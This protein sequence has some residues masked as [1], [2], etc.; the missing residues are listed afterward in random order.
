MAKKKN[1]NKKKK[2]GNIINTVPQVANSVVA[3]SIVPNIIIAP[4]ASGQQQGFQGF[5]V[6]KR[7]GTFWPN[8]IYDITPTYINTEIKVLPND[9][10]TNRFSKYYNSQNIFRYINNPTT[11]NNKIL[12]EYNFIDYNYDELKYTLYIGTTANFYC[13]SATSRLASTF[14]FTPSNLRIADTGDFL[15][16]FSVNYKTTFDTISSFSYVL[17][18]ERLF[19]YPIE[20]YY[21]GNNYILKTNTVLLSSVIYIYYGQ[22]S[23]NVAYNKIIDYLY[24]NPTSYPIPNTPPYS[25]ITTISAYRSVRDRRIGEI[26]L[27]N[28]ISNAFLEYDIDAPNKFFKIRPDSTYITYDTDYE[29]NNSIGQTL[30]ELDY[31]GLPDLKTSLILRQDLKTDNNIQ[32]FQLA[33]SSINTNLKLDDINNTI[34]TLTLNLTSGAITHNIFSPDVDEFGSSII[35]ITANFIGASY[36]LDS[37]YFIGN[38][39][40]DLETTKNTTGINNILTHTLKYPPHYYSINSYYVNNTP[41]YNSGATSN[42]NFNLSTG[43][44]KYFYS[45]EKLKSVSA[46]E[47]LSYL[48]SN[49]NIL[50]LDFE[51]YCK[52]D[53]IIFYP[54]LIKNEINE[55]VATAYLSSLECFYGPNL[56]VYYDLNNPSYIPAVSATK[57]LI[58]YPGEKYGEFDL[59][60][61]SSLSCSDLT[62]I[63][64]DRVLRINFSNGKP[65][66]AYQYPIY[67]EKLREIENRMDLS[68]ATLSA[69][70][71]FS[72]KDLTNSIISW[73]YYPESDNIKM[74]TIDRN[75]FS[76]YQSSDFSNYTIKNGESLLFLENTSNICISGYGIDSVTVI[77]SSQKYNETA[78]IKNVLYDYFYLNDSDLRINSSKISRTDDIVNLSLSATRYYHGTLLPI[79]SSADL[80]WNFDYFNKNLVELYYSDGVTRYNENDIL[81]AYLLSSIQVKINPDYNDLTSHIKPFKINLNLLTGSDKTL[82]TSYSID[83]YLLPFDEVMNVDFE[84]KANKITS[85]ENKTYKTRNKTN[86]ITRPNNDLNSFTFK[87]NTDIIPLLSYDTLTWIISTDVNYSYT[88]SYNINQDLVVDF[89]NIYQ[90]YSNIKKATVTLS[91]VKAKLPGWYIS[92]NLSSIFTLNLLPKT[93]LDQKLQFQI[94][95][96]YTWLSASSGFITLL[97]DSNYRNLSFSP[98]AYAN[99]K[100]LSQNFY[101][102]S[103]RNYDSYEYYSGSNLLYL[104]TLSSSKGEIEIPYSNELYSD[105]GSVI[106]LSAFK[107][108]LFP[109]HDGISYTGVTLNNTEYTGYFPVFANTLPYSSTYIRTTSAFL[110]S[111]KIIE[112]N[113]NVISFYVNSTSIDLDNNIF[114]TVTQNITGLNV[115][116]PAKISDTNDIKTITYFLSCK[117]WQT[118]VSIPAV[119][120]TYDLF[121]LR[122]GDPSEV[123]NI[124]DL[125]ITTLALQI[126]SSI[127]LKIPKTTFQY[128]S[129]NFK[130]DIDLWNEKPISIISNPVTI[131]AYSTSVKPNI[132]IS[133][134]YTIT[135]KEIYFEFETPENYLNY[136]ISSYDLFFGDGLSAKVLNNSKIYKTYYENNNYYISFLAN[137]TNGTST[138]FEMPNPIIVFD[139]WPYYDQNKIRLL[140]E[141]QLYFG[142]VNENTY[143]LN[144]IEIQPNEWGDVDI[145]NTAIYRLYSNL[146]YLRDNCRTLISNSPE[147][148]YGW[149]GTNQDKKS[150]GISWHTKDYKKFYFNYPNKATSSG[151]NYFS[152]LKDVVENK[153]R[154]FV[155][156]ETTIRA[157]SSSKIPQEIVFDNKQLIDDLLV[158]PISIDMD[159]SGENIYVADN[160]KNKIYKL[161]LDFDF[162]PPQVNVQLN[163]GNFGKREDPSKLNSP[164]EIIYKKELLFVLDY[165]NRCIKQY[166]KDLNWTFTY[167]TD[168]FENDQPLTIAIHPEDL[169]VYVLTEN[170]KIY[171]FE[172]FNSDIFEVID[173]SDI[174]KN[175][176]PLKLFFDEGGDFIYILT[177][178]E[179]YKY[180]T[181]GLYVTNTTIPNLENLNLITGKSSFYRSILVLTRNSIIK[182]SDIIF[183]QEIGEGLPYSYWNEEQIKLNRDDLALDLNYNTSLIRLCQ[184]IKQFRDNLNSKFIIVSEKENFGIIEYYSIYPISNKIKLIFSDDIENENIVVGVNEFHIPQVLNREFKKIYTALEQL[185]DYLEV[186]DVRLIDGNSGLSDIC[187]G[188]FCWSWK[189]MSS[190]DLKFPVLKVCNI[191]PIT[192]SELSSDFSSE[193]S[194]AP[195]KTF[196]EASSDCCNSLKPPI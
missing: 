136:K 48:F 160:F 117:Y 141:N 85:L 100:S 52:D 101:V 64:N 150:E 74:I 168:S 13:L 36:K 44:A 125:E 118:D 105:L 94:Y 192:Y 107:D 76:P 54:Y 152:N 145:F 194:Y 70:N 20:S 9:P 128:V 63:D 162:Y 56:N 130:G 139:E 16:F 111:P 102:S 161:N 175:N 99:K 28:V 79:P 163:V 60:L 110:Q 171:I 47:L 134:Y 11:D 46:V 120:G 7:S 93:F 8:E 77:L 75:T 104:N 183:Y 181:S 33:Q 34:Q 167:Y 65:L 68:C 35:P 113:S 61:F 67:I 157:F 170:Y 121:I 137:Y 129:S 124:R 187:T 15:N 12:N 42:L 133:S 25:I 17:I 109:K 177:E 123:L 132:F 149:L 69:D 182:F 3:S 83:V 147:V 185:R 169:F 80:Y 90:Q 43:I 55:V 23:Q 126:S 27:D 41:P 5:S 140:S 24:T 97:N 57:F 1:K 151:S 188:T 66:S 95:S 138:Y 72:T 164:T 50:K 31:F 106:Y 112:Y 26:D 166:T 189:G 59:F 195:S 45:D 58:R 39:S 179:I 29:N 155:I 32:I 114:L 98:T 159:E 131:F 73:S 122:I 178:K 116:N 158:N 89:Y 135:G 84:I 119:N 78:T 186:I 87:G 191:N 40:I 154:I 18:P 10:Y 174:D 82:T 180:S 108:D 51:T 4:P 2:P 176:T 49:F 53:K 62:E 173:I 19:N 143:T 71:L 127:E 156:D 21:D 153:D 172:Y 184:N 14:S 190:Y 165:N 81:D 86:I 115:N 148:Y 146:Q 6:V 37:S 38:S 196:G 22:F 193:Y 88:T 96:P 30:P 142:N 91:A 92:R 144:E 103:N